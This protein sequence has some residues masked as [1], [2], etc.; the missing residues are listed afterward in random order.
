MLPGVTVTA[1]SPSL[2]GANTAITE[3]DGRY[4]FPSLPSGRYTLQFELS[5]FQTVKRENIVLALGQT[6]SVRHADCSSRRCRR[7]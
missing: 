1:T 5:G 2:L 3:A 4:L 6:L 7:R